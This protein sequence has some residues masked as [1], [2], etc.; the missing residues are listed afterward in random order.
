MRH[1]HEPG[2]ALQRNEPLDHATGEGVDAE[3]P[4]KTFPGLQVQ[5]IDS[6]VASVPS[7]LQGLDRPGATEV[8]HAL[9]GFHPVALIGPKRGVGNPLFDSHTGP[10]RRHTQDRRPAGSRVYR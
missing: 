6:G 8:M 5:E 10:C 1:F 2:G 3:P 7:R 4:R 9:K